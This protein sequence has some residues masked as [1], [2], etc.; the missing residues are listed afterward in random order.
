ML[1][2]ISGTSRGIGKELLNTF[3]TEKNVQVIAVSRSKM[4]KRH[5]LIGVKGDINT[6]KGRMAVLNAV[7]KTGMK[8]DI[9][10]NNAGA[11]VKKPFSSVSGKDLQL[12]Y[13]A[14]VFA[15]YLLLQKLLPKMNTS[16]GSHV[17][18]IGSMGGVQ[19]S[20]KFSGLSAYS[21]SKAAIAGWTECL[22]EELKEKKISLN[23]LSIG[24][25]Q[26]EMLSKAFPGYRAP[27]KPSEMASFI[28]WFAM[29]GHHYFN[30]KIL[31]V[32]ST[33]P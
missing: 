23:C 21:S 32:S 1:V 17:V 20:S 9:I 31:P 33:T 10:I 18:N 2:I 30:G 16:K 5:G 28:K 14:N 11:L 15:P 24:A 6:E 25:V 13:S 29:N 27:L 22:A 12:V 3:L 8:V 19:G 7:K 26:T 4:Q